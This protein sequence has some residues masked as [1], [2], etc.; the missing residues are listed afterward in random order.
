MLPSPLDKRSPRNGY[1][2]STIVDGVY[3]RS[4]QDIILYN[5][6]YR[7]CRATKYQRTVHVACQFY[8]AET[9]YFVTATPLVITIP[10]IYSTN[11]QA[12]RGGPELSINTSPAKLSRDTQA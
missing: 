8:S 9:N 6:H 12:A 10:L 5:L 1:A 7:Y 11:I 3:A 4:W 2:T